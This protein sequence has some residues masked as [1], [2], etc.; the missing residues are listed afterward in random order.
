LPGA[1]SYRYIRKGP[2]ASVALL[3]GC[4]PCPSRGRNPEE[5]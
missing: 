2:G 4:T 5:I 3:V 1:A